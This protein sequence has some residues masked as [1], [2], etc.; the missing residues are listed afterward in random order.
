MRSFAITALVCTVTAAPATVFEPGDASRCFV[1]AAG[2][3]RVEFTGDIH[4]SFKC[5]H[6]ADNTAC[7]CVSNHP[8]REYARLR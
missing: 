2:Q 3:T 5:A 1:T 8:T 7:S 4:P 6:N